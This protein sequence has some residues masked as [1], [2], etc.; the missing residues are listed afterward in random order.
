MYSEGGKQNR[1]YT[2]RLKK[3]LRDYRVNS[4]EQI[5]NNSHII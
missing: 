2:E 3:G 5:N 1:F 4:K